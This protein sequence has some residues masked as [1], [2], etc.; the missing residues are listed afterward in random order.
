MYFCWRLVCS[1]FLF[2][3]ILCKTLVLVDIRN[4][5]LSEHYDDDDDVQPTGHIDYWFLFILGL[6]VG[7]G[8]RRI[9]GLQK[10][11]GLL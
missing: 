1:R 7:H 5:C 4:L 8:H 11:V 6:R 3:E 9:F 2:V 10:Y